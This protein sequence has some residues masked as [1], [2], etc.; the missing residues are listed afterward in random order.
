MENPP[1]IHKD[2]YL[3]IYNSIIQSVVCRET[4]KQQANLPRFRSY[5]KSITLP[6]LHITA[7][8]RGGGKPQS[9]GLQQSSAI[10]K[11]TWP[12]LK[13]FALKMSQNI[14]KSTTSTVSYQ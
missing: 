11:I 10:F 8:N 1:V 3:E 9:G 5:S 14:A 2:K 6:T 13:L 12:K 7:H 4:L